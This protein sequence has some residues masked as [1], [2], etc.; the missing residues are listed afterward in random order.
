M[1]FRPVPHS[2]LWL[3]FATTFVVAEAYS[4]LHRASYA[5]LLL[6]SRMAEY[7]RQPFGALPPHLTVR[8]ISSYSFLQ[9]YRLAI[10]ANN[11]SHDACAK[12]R[13]TM[14]E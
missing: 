10:S 13:Q 14:S 7:Q 2:H 11:V 3:V 12:I 4:R 5:S 9:N 8:I 6:V 1:D